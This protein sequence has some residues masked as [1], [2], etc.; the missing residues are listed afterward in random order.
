MNGEPP[1]E[2]DDGSAADGESEL[3]E[4]FGRRVNRD[5]RLI[6]AVKVL[7]ELLP[8]D[9]RF[10]DPLST[11]GAADAEL[12]GRQL[13]QVSKER[14]GVLGEAGLGALQLWQAIAQ[15]GAGGGTAE[16]LTI[17]FTDL[18]GFSEW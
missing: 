16:E 4:S 3:K 11:A 9:S 1:A 12:I 13:A 15:A 6:R 5:P 2:S 8:G 7:R 17:V 14:P 10:G 18:A